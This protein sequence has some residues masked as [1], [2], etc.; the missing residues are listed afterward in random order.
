MVFRLGSLVAIILS[1]WEKKAFRFAA[2]FASL[3]VNRPF[4][5]GAHLHDNSPCFLVVSHE[6]EFLKLNVL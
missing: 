2:V 6:P 5:E 1:V 3:P 4:L